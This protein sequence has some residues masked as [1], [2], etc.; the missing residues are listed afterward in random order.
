MRYQLNDKCERFIYDHGWITV[1]KDD[2]E[3]T[4]DVFCQMTQQLLLSV[5]SSF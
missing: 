2:E 4:F 5:L 1:K 3:S